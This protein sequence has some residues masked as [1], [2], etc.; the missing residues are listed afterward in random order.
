MKWK[1]NADYINNTYKEPIIIAAA[2]STVAVQ[3][4]DRGPRMSSTMVGHGSQDHNSRSY[5]IHIMKIGH[6]I[7]CTACHMMQTP[8]PTD[9]YL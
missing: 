7:I 4:E 9:T 6:I 5:R 1:Q 3:R 2:G 8:I